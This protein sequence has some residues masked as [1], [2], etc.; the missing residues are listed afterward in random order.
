MSR[1]SSVSVAVAAAALMALLAGAP[2]AAQ[3]DEIKSLT[4]T[5]IEIVLKRIGTEFE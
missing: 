3:A 4:A 2:V 1:Q 5:V